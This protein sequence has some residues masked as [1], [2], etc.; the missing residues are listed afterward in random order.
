MPALHRVILDT[1]I[2]SDVDDAMALAQLLGTDVV[3]LIGVTTV[4]GDTTL[5]ARFAKRLAGAAGRAIDVYAGRAEPLSGKEVWWAG[6][7][8]VLHEALDREEIEGQDAVGFLVEQVLRHPRQID[9]VA[10][11]PLTNIAAAIE[12]EPR[13]AEAVRHLWIMGGAFDDDET[14]HNLRSDSSAASVVFAAGISTTVTGL[15]V[16]RLVEIGPGQLERIAAAGGIG[17][18]LKAE[19]EQWWRY[20]DVEWNV[21]HDP[22]AVLTMT[23]PELFTTSEPGTVTIE[24]AGEQEG[25]STFRPG[26]GSTR[27][28]RS[29]DAAAVSGR[30]VEAIVACGRLTTKAGPST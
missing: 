11:G 1:D 24:L 5:R 14:E 16:T 25:R 15:E 22:V 27:V 2:G 19:I 18:M 26:E 6:H 9:I 23:E 4:Y 20:W 12:A 21:P 17:R 3:E 29:L 30:I 7:E 28:I 13:F 10:I 8:G